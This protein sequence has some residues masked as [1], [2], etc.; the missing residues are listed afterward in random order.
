MCSG[1]WARGSSSA[2]GSGNTGI[3]TGR[4]A[5]SSVVATLALPRRSGEQNGGQ[6]APRR[7]AERVLKADGVE[8]AQQARSGLAL[9]PVA[10]TTDDFQQVVGSALAVA[11]GHQ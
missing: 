1:R 2:P 7:H 4:A 3:T 6:L 10:V 11:H 8:H 5:G 9:S